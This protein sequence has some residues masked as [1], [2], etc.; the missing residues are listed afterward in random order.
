MILVLL[1]RWDQ[2]GKISAIE[3]F[4]RLVSNMSKQDKE[5]LIV[6]PRPPAPDGAG[7]FG[8]LADIIPSPKSHDWLEGAGR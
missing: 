8:G 2:L 6:F 3:R 1:R 5:F 4:C 7:S